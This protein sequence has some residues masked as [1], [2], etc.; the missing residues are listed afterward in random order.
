M[1]PNETVFKQSNLFLY[2]SGNNK[3]PLGYEL[4][5]WGHT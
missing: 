2:D 1:Q 3:P 5:C 4:G